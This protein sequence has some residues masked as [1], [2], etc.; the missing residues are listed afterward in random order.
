MERKSVVLVKWLRKGQYEAWSS[1][2]AFVNTHQGYT[3]AI[4]YNNATDGVF[5]DGVIEL[6]RI[7]FRL[8]PVKTKRGNIK[9]A[10]PGPK[11]TRTVR[12]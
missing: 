11:P 10:K 2:S 6:R 8:N 3:R 1:L 12:K 5:S 4:I 9:R 7:P